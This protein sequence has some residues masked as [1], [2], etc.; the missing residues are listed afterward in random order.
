MPEWDASPVSGRV[1]IARLA[2][3]V[4]AVDDAVSAT[5]GRERRWVTADGD[6]VIDGVVVAAAGRGRVDVQLHV[7]ALWPTGPLQELAAQLRLRLRRSF[8]IAGVGD[9]VGDVDVAF[10]D[11]RARDEVC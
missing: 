5:A 7:V 8:S 4:V 9:Q 3:Q 10:H 2:E 6:R 1:L 11:V